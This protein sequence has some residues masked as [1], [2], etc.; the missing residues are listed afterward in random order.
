MENFSYP[1]MSPAR[2]R[3]GCV[4]FHRLATWSTLTDK[5][6][7]D[8]RRGGLAAP[9]HGSGTVEIEVTARRHSLEKQAH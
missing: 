7:D 5:R 2:G 9:A 4:L 3:A 1:A 8:P 6:D